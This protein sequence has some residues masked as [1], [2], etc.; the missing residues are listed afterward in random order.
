MTFEASLIVAVFIIVATLIGVVAFVSYRQRLARED[1]M[2][3]EAS[4][5][6]W[7]F[8]SLVERGYRVHRWSGTSDGIAWTAESLSRVNKGKGRRRR[9]IARWHGRFAPGIN[10]PIVVLGVPKGSETPSFGLAQGEGFGARLVQKVAGAAFDVA[11]DMYF[12]QDAG[13][14]VDAARL[15]RLDGPRIPG[16]I[17]SAE[18]KDEAL[19]VLADGLERALADASND[20]SSVLSDNDRPYILLRRNHVS[21]ARM[22]PFRGIADLE[23][24]IRAG[25][26][27]ARHFRFGRPS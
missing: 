18:D 17:V 20:K 15:S 27:L 11:V 24:F 19:R 10:K 26:S 13:A 5:R 4:K 21:L 25:T 2:R 8:E 3:Q 23:A 1:E 7:K 22:E 16:F 9:Q 14:E 12:G 6:G